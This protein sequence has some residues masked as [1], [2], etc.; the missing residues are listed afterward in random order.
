[1]D[2]EHLEELLRNKEREL[3]A[4]LAGLEGE[5][6]A[7]G[8][9]EVKDSIDRATSSQATSKSFEEGAPVSQTLEQVQA[10]LHRLKDGTYGRCPLWTPD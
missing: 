8:E 10:A 7:S 9:S 4:N 6:R 3:Q 5:E 1:M 2:T